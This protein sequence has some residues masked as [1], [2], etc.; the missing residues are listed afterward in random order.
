MTQIA[1]TDGALIRLL[2]GCGF[3]GVDIA[4]GP[5]EWDG[6]Y[7]QRLLTS[8]PAIRVVFMGA[9]PYTDTDKSTT[10]SMAGKWAAYVI[11]G[12]NGQNEKERRIG[13]GAGHDL[14]HRTASALHSAILKDDNGDRLPI[15]SV[16]GLDVLADSALDLSNLWIAAVEISV[17]LPLDL[18]PECTG[19]LDDFLRIRGA[20]VLPDPAEDIEIAVD[21]DQT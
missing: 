12:W 7:V 1:A 14:L 6:G 15:A 4:S 10:L 11:V 5:H 2:E 18:M 13:A 16:T 20:L 3:P 21:L 9:E 8:T 19:P 17:E